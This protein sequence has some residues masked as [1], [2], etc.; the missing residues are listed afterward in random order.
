MRDVHYHLP[1]PARDTPQPLPG[2][3]FLVP[4]PENKRFV[5]R[6]GI[7]R[8]LKDSLFDDEHL[9]STA[10]VGL[11]GVGKT[12]VALQIAYRAR[13][14][15]SWSVFWLP[16]LSKAAFDQACTEVV[17]R[18]RIPTS[19]TEEAKQVV[20]AYLESNASGRWLLVVDNAQGCRQINQIRLGPKSD[21]N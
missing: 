8:R 2:P 14:L 13:T 4:F 1:H 17:E 3:H 10:V 20:K 9:C 18:L 6:E 5:G 21:L 15:P 16:A 12:Q 7:L 19:G 11:G